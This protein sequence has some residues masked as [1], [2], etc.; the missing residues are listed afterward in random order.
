MD[1]FHFGPNGDLFGS[2]TP[3][4]S[5]RG[6]ST[7]AVLC[8]PFG[9]E[10][11][12]AHRAFRQLATLLAR[13]GVPVLR[14]DYSNTGDSGGHQEAGR[15]GRWVGDVR[16]AVEEARRRSGANEVRIAGLRLGA[17][18]AM[19]ASEGC[20]DVERL[21][22]WDP[23]VRGSSLLDGAAP[24]AN[25]V[26]EDTLWVSGF[27]ISSR[28]REDIRSVDLREVRL[29]PSVRIIQMISH[30]HRAFDELAETWADHP[31]GAE[32]R[33]I[34]SP[35]DWNYIDDVGGILVP[36]EMVLGVVDAMGD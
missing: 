21:V 6:G 31:G 26:D 29:P 30:P 8:Y 4:A 9:Q 34:D 12:R 17:S 14:F 10:Y 33:L 3:P 23:V 27:P 15:I 1:F 32:T 11:M 7:V 24:Q 22:L 19:M 28:L 20:V 13:R 2:F 16:A 35:S 25:G 36:R 18:L 5:G